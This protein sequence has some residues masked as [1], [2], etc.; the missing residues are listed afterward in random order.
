MLK[1]PIQITIRPVCYSSISKLQKIFFNVFVLLFGL[2]SCH[3]KSIE[4][5]VKYHYRISGSDT[6]LELVAS[7]V[8]TYHENSMSKAIFEMHGGGSSKGIKQL[9]NGQADI[10]N[11]S[12]LITSDDLFENNALNKNIV[13]AIIAMDAI[14]IITHTHLGVQNLSLA[15]LSNIFSGKITNWKEVGGPDRTIH[16]YGRDS[17][18]GTQAFLKNKLVGDGNFTEINVLKN[19]KD[20]LEAVR[21]D[22]C[23]VGY[24]GIGEIRDEMER[25]DASIWAVNLYIEGG[26]PFSPYELRPVQT[27]DYPLSRPL[28][29]YFNGKPRNELLK[30]LE[31][32]L[33][34]AG[35]ELVRQMGYFPITDIHRQINTENGLG[36]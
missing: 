34:P 6:E 7:L 29:Q 22:S 18:S 4:K 30:L 25:P 21:K 11:S 27:G 36:L 24:V 10:A 19:Q 14:A 26:K 32:E 35:Q 3:D 15:Q 16:I 5:N 31:F 12:R 9:L 20:I 28:L 23:G 8:K 17:N 1:N 33:S 13:Q 2:S